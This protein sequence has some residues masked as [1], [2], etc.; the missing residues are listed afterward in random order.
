MRPFAP[1]GDQ[2]RPLDPANPEIFGFGLTIGQAYYLLIDGVDGD[3]CKYVITVAFGST[4]PPQLGQLDSI[5]GLTKVCPKATTSYSIPA[6]VDFALSY[7]WSAPAGAKING[8][9]NTAVIPSPIGSSVGTSVDIQFGTLGGLVCVTASNACDTPKTTCILIENGPLPINNLPEITL[10][11]EELPFIWEESPNQ[12]VLAPGT[13][14]LTS[15]PYESYLGCDSIVRQKIVALKRK[16]KDLPPKY[17]CKDECFYIGGFEYCDPGPY[18]EIIPS[19]SGCDS[20]VTFT[21]F[22]IPVNAQAQVTDT[23]T[24]KK[25]SVVLHSAGSSTGNTFFYRWINSSGTVISNADTAVVTAPGS[26]SLIVTNIAAGLSCEDT[27]TVMVVANTTAPFAN[28]GP[29][30]IIDCDE[31]LIQI[32]GTGST[33][34]QYSYQ[35][36]LVID[37]NI[38][39]GGNTLTPTV[40]APGTYRLVVTDN[41]NG[42][43]AGNNAKV[44]ADVLP[45]SVSA[46]GGSYSCKIPSVT[47]QVNTNAN[48]PVY[49]WTGP[50]SFT[51]SN[52]NP[53]VNAPGDY[54][55]VV[56]DGV[57][58]CTNAAIATVV[59]NTD[60]PGA[61]ATGGIINCSVSSVIL[62]GSTQATNPLYAWM[63]PNGFTSNIAN[64]TV[65]VAGNYVLTVTGENG[66]TS[67]AS[68]DVE[69]D[70]TQPGAALAVSGNLNCNNATVTLTTSSVNPSPSLTYVWTLPDNST[71]STDIDPTLPANAPGSYSV[72]VTNPEN[73][74][75]S[76]ANTTVIQNPVVTAQISSVTDVLCFGGTT[77]SAGVVAN[78]GNGAYTYAWSGNSGTSAVVNGLASGDYIVTIT[79][80]EQC[81]ASAT[82]TVN[83]PDL[84][85]TN[86]SATPE[87]TNG[88]NDGS[89]SASPAGGVAPYTYL[90]SNNN[91]VTPGISN[92]APGL[93][94]VTVTDDNGC[95]AVQTV[96]VL[97]GDCGLSANITSVSPN[98]TGE[99]TGSATVSLAGGNGPFTYLWSANNGTDPT[100]IGIAAGNYTVTVT[101]VN[102]CTFS[103]EVNVV[104]PPALTIAVDNVVNTS[105][106]NETNGSATVTAGGGT[107]VLS[108]LWN[109]N[110]PGPTATGLAPGTYTAVV[111]DGKGCTESIDATVQ[112][113]DT[114]LPVIVN[115][116][117]TAP[118]GNTGNVTLSVQSLGLTVSDNCGLSTVT[119]V[120]STF[121]C[122]QLGPHDVAVTAT[123]GSGNVTVETI[124]VTIIDNLSPALECP[125]NVVRC[126]YDPAVQYPAPVAMDNCLGIGGSFNMPSGL[127]SG[128]TFP[129]G[130]TTNTFTYTDANGNVG[131]CSFTV[132][133]LA[134]LTA[135]EDTIVNDIDNQ[136]IGS[137]DIDV[138]GGL[139]PYTYL[140][141]FNG[142]TLP[143]TTEDLS[144]LGAGEYQVFIV[145]AAGCTI[146]SEVYTVDNLVDT[147][148]PGWA[149][150]LLIVPNPTSGRLSVIFPQVMNQQ[151]SLAVYDMTGRLLRQQ[152]SEA[153]KRV[154]FDLSALPGGLYKMEIVVNEQFIVRKIVITR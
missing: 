127:A 77:G 38:V 83:Q 21:L 26:Y 3:L 91:E 93:Y 92:L 37:G 72:V 116:P 61:D 122:T 59:D 145:D 102:G 109:N 68:A 121:N 101:D 136:N 70:N 110:Q 140:W 42:C 118:L 105:C 84:L 65:T 99:A 86:A 74:C 48:N 73:G 18:Q 56:T 16:A 35:W 79:D 143:V 112:A 52:P 81:T 23:L 78:G 133:V 36:V 98:C 123:D 32:Q 124:V 113:I 134:A 141:L 148:E 66:C 5:Q 64:P 106:S 150:G 100:L 25:T 1:E 147:E 69:L 96:Q 4:E 31:P 71:T 138:V 10:C 114:E 135:T 27:A 75:T 154:D 149:S 43:T 117:V 153:P 88:A 132:N 53:V 115:N 29:D 44:T 126:S 40:N 152:V 58:G 67:T 12:A 62:G 131:S 2:L 57:T 129:E 22:K 144:N 41:T 47:L 28:A 60:L 151:V 33:G 111:T 82:A 128:S 17:L 19:E 89:A 139:A 9:G 95:T 7:I 55:I 119:F 76:T 11:F 13:Y 90:W 24:C 8:G 14:T 6:P 46:T 45:P 120:P 97:A 80:G 103:G 137:I 87:T 130:V 15:S 94:T 49:Q 51:S 142:D 50:N 63:G 107:G 104:D 39:S 34:S 20:T 30:R 85:T 54:T 146:A 125:P 108:I